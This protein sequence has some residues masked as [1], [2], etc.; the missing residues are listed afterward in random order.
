MNE[1]G[2]A[3][4]VRL[5]TPDT[6]DFMSSPLSGVP[7]EKRRRAA[8]TVGL[9]AMLFLTI[10][11][12]A[13]AGRSASGAP[14]FSGITIS[15]AVLLG[16]VAWGMIRSIGADLADRELDA[17]IEAT[18]ANRPEF[19][20]LCSCGHDHDPTELHLTDDEPADACAHDGG[21][22]SCAHDCSTCVLTALRPS[23][24]QTRAERLTH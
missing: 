9:F 17:A 7:I 24:N 19:A 23:P 1:A 22:A 18:L 20:S 3:H 2:D 6:L 14:V 11:I 10:G 5:P 21:G 4:S 16:L 12:V 8:A 13:A 15:I